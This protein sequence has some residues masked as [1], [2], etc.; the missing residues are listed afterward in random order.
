MDKIKSTLKITV[1]LLLMVFITSCSKKVVSPEVAKLQSQQELLD[2]NSKLN[3]LNL[4]LEKKLAT[5]NGLIKD[6]E[7]ANKRASNS[8]DDAKKRS[9]ELSKNPGD[10]RVASKA[11]RA[12]KRAAKDVKR[13]A[14]L[15]SKL[16]DANDE[17]KDLQKDIKDTQ[18]KLDDLQSK[19]NFVPN[20]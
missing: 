5:V 20:Q 7:K 19:I 2:L 9:A 1:A 10:S 4:S 8:A 11:E 17:V 14:K 13:A 18:S 12:S 16:S 6:V 15:N 3:K